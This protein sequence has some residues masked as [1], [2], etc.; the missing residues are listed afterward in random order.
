MMRTMLLTAFLL[1]LGIVVAEI[2]ASSLVVVLYVVGRAICGFSSERH[3]P[4][5]EA[6]LT[7]IASISGFCS[8]AAI[9]LS[10]SRPGVEIH[11]SFVASG[12]ARHA[13]SSEECRSEP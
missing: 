6:T 3:S 7:F 13:N 5:L 11:R 12:C 1:L 8:V 9:E 4:E 10:R 2:I